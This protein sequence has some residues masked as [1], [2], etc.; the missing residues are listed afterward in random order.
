[1]LKKLR[2]KFVAIIM[3][4][5]AVVLVVV[6]TAICVINYQQS[7]NRVHEALDGSLASLSHLNNQSQILQDGQID[8]TIPH[9]NDQTPKGSSPEIGGKRGGSDPFIPVAVYSLEADG[10]LTATQTERVTASLAEDVLTRASEQLAELPEGSGTLTDL[11]LFYAKQ[12]INGITYFAFADMSTANDWQNLALILAGVGALAL[13]VF[14]VISVLFSRWALHPVENAW[15]QQ[16]RFIAD[17][18]HELKTPLTVIL[19]NASILLE[20]PE[21]SI[22]SESQWIE[23][24]QTEADRMQQLVGDL[25]L[26]AR[27]DEGTAQTTHEH[28]DLTDLVEG[29]LLQFESVAFERKVNLLSEIDRNVT[30]AGDASRLHRLVTTLV[31]NA[32]KYANEGGS[33]RVILHQSMK[34]ITLS[35]HNTGSAIGPDDLLHVFDRFYRADKARVRDNNSYGLGLAI[36][37]GVAEE[38]GGTLEATSSESEGTTFLAVLPTTTTQPNINK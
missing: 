15:E 6:F 28:I 33:V 24:T 11:G 9:S 16:R 25:L 32:C 12:Q 1:M 37:R 22:A 19:A 34:N 8:P 7:L 23:S 17:A 30:I 27:I 26:L 38:H 2:I 13:M 29:E 14:F 31:D 5:I 3:S 4:M 18:S 21:R 35:V 20:H 10:S 36:A